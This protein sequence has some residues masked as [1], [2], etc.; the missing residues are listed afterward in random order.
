MLTADSRS[1]PQLSIRTQKTEQLMARLKHNTSG[2]VTP[3]TSIRA[4]PATGGSRKQNT[5][6]SGPVVSNKPAVQ[7]KTCCNMELPKNGKCPNCSDD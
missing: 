4:T 7:P 6:R 1:V 5:S 3:V 2:R